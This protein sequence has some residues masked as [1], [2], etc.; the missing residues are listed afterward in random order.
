[1]PVVVVDID[2]GLLGKVHLTRS[3]WDLL[4]EAYNARGLGFSP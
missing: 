4:L 3:F 2:P 1:M